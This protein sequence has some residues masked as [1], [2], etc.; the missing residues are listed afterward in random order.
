MNFTDIIKIVLGTGVLSAILNSIISHYLT[1]RNEEKIESNRVK[2]EGTFLAIRLATTLE[3]FAHECQNLM[4]SNQNYFTTGGA[5]GNM[6]IM[7]PK[8]P[9]YPTDSDWK[10]L[11]VDLAE[12]A[13]SFRNEVKEAQYYIDFEIEINDNEGG[14]NEFIVVSRRIGIASLKIAELLRKNY[15]LPE[16]KHALEL[17]NVFEYKEDGAARDIK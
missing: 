12:A 14:A 9:E 1:S 5:V 6:Y 16:Y 10:C 17:M 13:L 11:N 4:A 15:G 3:G 7:L 2:R 8:I